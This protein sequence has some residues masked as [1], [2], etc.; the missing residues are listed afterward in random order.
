MAEGNGDHTEEAKNILKKSISFVLRDKG[1][2]IA[3]KRAQKAL[4]C[5]DRVLTWITDPVTLKEALNLP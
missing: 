1:F 2:S 5:A 3:S 4:T